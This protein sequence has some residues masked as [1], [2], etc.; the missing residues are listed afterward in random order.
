MNPPFP[1]PDLVLCLVMD[2]K[3][4]TCGG[5]CTRGRGRSG[6][7]SARW[8]GPRA[9][10]GETCAD[11]TPHHTKES[12]RCEQPHL[13]HLIL[14]LGGAAVGGG[15][16]VPGCVRIIEETSPQSF[17]TSP[18]DH[19]A[20]VCARERAREQDEPTLPPTRP[21]GQGSRI[22]G[23]GRRRRR[24]NREQYSTRA[25]GERREDGWHAV[26]MGELLHHAPDGHVAGCTPAEMPMTTTT[27]MISASGQPECGHRRSC[28]LGR[29]E[30]RKEGGKGG[31]G[32]GTYPHTTNALGGLSG[33]L[34][35]HH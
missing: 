20:I 21:L 2:R 19:H 3:G 27:T 35:R 12:G 16:T 26:L 6:R 5:A 17:G 11:D 28:F 13:F 1:Q 18:G 33:R 29:K 8:C 32:L 31:G 24:R 15:R 34:S 25:K 4:S 30:G 9:S 23:G 7:S 22:R 14:F 10:A